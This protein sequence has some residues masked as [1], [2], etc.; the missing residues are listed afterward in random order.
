MKEEIL[1]YHIHIQ[2]EE[3]GSLYYLD[4]LDIKRLEDKIIQPY[5]TGEEFM[6]C[7]FYIE[8]SKV[9]KLKV[10]RT[11]SHSEQLFRDLNRDLGKWKSELNFKEEFLFD[12]QS[13]SV[14]DVTT[15]LLRKKSSEIFT[16]TALKVAAK[17]SEKHKGQKSN[18]F[19]DQ[20]LLDEDL[21]KKSTGKEDKQILG[22]DEN[23]FL[24][25]SFRQV[26][27]EFVSGFKELLSYNGYSVIDGKADRTGSI[28]EAILDKI[29]VSDMVIIVMTKRD[30]KENE[31]YTTSSWLLEE[32]GAALALGKEVVMFVEQEIDGDDI[33]G[34]Q[35]D[36]QRFHFTRN[37]FLKVVMNFIKILEES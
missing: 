9:K 1:Y 29:R 28:S 31:K 2:T 7:G 23:I 30:K 18:S 4:D 35:G 20:L 24:S 34:M 22:Q 25:Y 15:E 3:T 11:D 21:A 27:D 16:V 12:S 10:T 8:P 17:A 33:G 14:S 5:L 19:I 26:D 6:F 13:P 37:N 32:K 36:A